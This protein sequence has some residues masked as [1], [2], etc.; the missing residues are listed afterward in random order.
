MLQGQLR[1]YE[2]T[3][4]A[5]AQLHQQ[6]VAHLKQEVERL[7]TQNAALSAKC[8]RLDG[9]LLEQTLMTGEGNR[10]YKAEIAQKERALLVLEEELRSAKDMNAQHLKSLKAS[11]ERSLR[12]FKK[13]LAKSQMLSA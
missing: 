6:E 1:Q 10:T 9:Q 8:R 4:R 7:K 2:A 12:Q 11:Q 13:E 5:D 3:A